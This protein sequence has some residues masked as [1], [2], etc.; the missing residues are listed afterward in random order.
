MSK[1]KNKIP[2][3]LKFKRAKNSSF[4]NK[5]NNILSY[6]K[7]RNSFK[8][9]PKKILLLRNDR[10]GDAVVTLPA[11]EAIKRNYP[12]IQ[13]DVLASSKNRFVFEKSAHVSEIYTLDWSTGR[14][15]IFKHLFDENF[16]N[17]MSRLKERNFDAVID[18]VGLK[19]NIIL[20]KYLSDFTVGPR[21]LLVYV[22]YTYYGDSNWVT[23]N[24]SDPMT[25]KIIKLMGNALNLN[26]TAT[27]QSERDMP[28]NHEYDIIIHLGSTHLRK[29]SSRKEE[30]LIEL[31]SGKKV[32]IT[33]GEDNDN[34]SELERKYQREK[35]FN[36]KLFNSLDELVEECKKAKIL[37]CYDGGQAHY[38]ARYVRTVAIFGPGSV[39]LWK[40][41]EHAEYELLEEDKTGVK[42][43]ISGGSFRHIVIYYPIWCRPCFDVGCESVKCLSMV[44]PG[45]IKYIVEK[46]CM[47]DAE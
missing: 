3:L 39:E 38:L 19:R 35:R 23:L 29:L 33:D 44:T 7:R 37:I 4:V 18:L 32:L 10:I 13:I 15:N 34:F 21:K 25:V 28:T 43:A 22:F 24:E 45:F 27:P 31:F 1:D 46:Y 2:L 26:L 9:I 36:F 16:K 12:D 6:I 41:Y 14:I 5:L 11:I 30:E 40:P 8:G 47:A 17:L 42:A 20:G